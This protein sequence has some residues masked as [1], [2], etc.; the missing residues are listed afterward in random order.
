[1]FNLKDKD[2]VASYKTT[3][4]NTFNE[5]Y[6][7][8]ALLVISA[9]NS[10]T[11]NYASAFLNKVITSNDERARKRNGISLDYISKNRKLY[12]MALSARNLL[13]EHVKNAVMSAR[14]QNGSERKKIEC[15]MAD[16]FDFTD[17][18]IFPLMDAT[19]E[20]TRK[21]IS[22]M[23][24]ILV[25]KD[26]LVDAIV[27]FKMS[28][29]NELIYDMIAN[30]YPFMKKN[31]SYTFLRMHKLYEK[32]TSILRI[33]P[34]TNEDGSEP[35][36]NINNLL[37]DKASL[38]IMDD[39]TALLLS[40]E[41]MDKIH[42]NINNLDPK[43]RLERKSLVPPLCDMTLPLIAYKQRYENFNYDKFVEKYIA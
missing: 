19:K 34:I 31:S 36:L 1:M 20:C 17:E 4:G 33:I 6:F 3:F 14:R 7:N 35:F 32:M 41:F 37:N 25:D 22:R 13:D 40:S 27:A 8:C 39:L 10:V 38:Y 42:Q 23:F 29:Y 18:K 11:I 21:V 43:F 26:L 30:S 16:L 24:P 2:A 5:F 28:V 15:D 12:S 9:L